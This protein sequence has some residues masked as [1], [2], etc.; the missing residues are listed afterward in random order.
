MRIRIYAGDRMLGPGKMELLG[1][2]ETTGSLSAAAK[3]MGMSYMRAWT[4]VRFFS[5]NMLMT[6]CCAECSGKFVVHRLD[7]HNNY[8]CGL[9]HLP[10]RA[11]K[12]KKARDAAALPAVAMA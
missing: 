1:H 9:C 11:G 4:L 5:S 10:S 8:T 2:I 3:R 6:T 7:L 12:T